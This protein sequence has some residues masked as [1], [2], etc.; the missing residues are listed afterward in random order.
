MNAAARMIALGLL[1]AAHAPELRAQPLDDVSSAGMPPESLIL[2]WPA[3]SYGLARMMLA[4]YGQPFEAS[5]HR[6]VWL[7]NGPWKKTVVYRNPPGESVLG[8]EAGRLEQSVAYRVPEDKLAALARFDRQIGVDPREGRITVL[9]N[10]ESVNFLALNL[11][12]EVVQ[13]RRTAREAALF[14]RKLLRLRNAGKFSHYLEGL[15]FFRGKA[16]NPESPD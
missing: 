14:R 8:S 12:D 5:D 3:R 11:A 16:G 15:L 10:S 1:L 9:S 13:G 6:L 4:E 7:E 2:L